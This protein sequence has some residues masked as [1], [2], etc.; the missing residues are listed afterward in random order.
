MSALFGAR[1]FSA[2]DPSSERFNMILSY[3]KSVDEQS[4]TALLENHMAFVRES[5]RLSKTMRKSDEK[6]LNE[7]MA[8]LN[9]SDSQ[10]KFV[11]Y[12]SS[13]RP[14]A[15]LGNAGR[16]NNNIFVS[17]EFVDNTMKLPGGREMLTATIA[18]ELSHGPRDFLVL[19]VLTIDKTLSASAKD[20]WR[21]QLEVNADRGAIE[22]LRNAGENPQALIRALKGF[23][24]LERA[25]SAEESLRETDQQK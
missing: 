7:I 2:P 19:R 22:L 24:E 25:N 11:T 5:V 4:F 8:T 20:H 14:G 18:H 6:L 1:V 13:G 10:V 21:L 16:V 3:A 9:V 17:E 15:I 12:R 23:G